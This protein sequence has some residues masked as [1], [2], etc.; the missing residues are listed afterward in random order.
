MHIRGNDG[1]LCPIPPLSNFVD[2]AARTLCTSITMSRP[3]VYERGFDIPSL[4]HFVEKHIENLG[5]KQ[6][7]ES[8]PKVNLSLVYEFYANF[9][10]LIS[11]DV[12]VKSKQPINVWIRDIH[13]DIS[14][15]AIRK[16]LKLPPTEAGV[17]SRVKKFINDCSIQFL[18]D[19]L[20][21]VGYNEPVTT[22]HLFS[23]YMSEFS[24][25]M[26]FL[27]RSLLFP[28]VITK[29]CIDAGV[30]VQ[31]DDIIVPHV[32]A[33]DF[34]IIHKSA[35]QAGIYVESLEHTALKKE[36]KEMVDGAVTAL[37]IRIQAI[38]S[39]LDKLKEFIKELATTESAAAEA[40]G[41]AAIPDNDSR[42]G[43]QE[44]A[45][46][47]EKEPMEDEVMETSGDTESGYHTPLDDK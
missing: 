12:K 2:P 15:L 6:A 1:T 28:A 38:D 46:S 33:V 43:S 32:Q 8:F 25:C 44:K 37:D 9:S 11:C 3:V 16:A 30:D 21:T 20:Y 7:L 10:E 39:K 40:G 42:S 41:G 34:V 29:L 36:L 18:G 26:S 19:K 27:V 4:P 5:W 31:D 35:G 23:Q 14:S 13:V 24:K 47:A 17:V 45:K 22:S